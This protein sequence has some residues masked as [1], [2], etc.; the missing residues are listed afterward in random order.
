MYLKVS[1]VKVL[2]LQKNGY[3]YSVRY[4][5]PVVPNWGVEHPVK[6][7]KINLRNREMIKVAG[8]KKKKMSATQICI[9]LKRAKDY[10]IFR[11]LY[12]L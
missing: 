10:R 3:L 9:K 1:K 2:V 6:G 8:K 4:F 12:I 11:S 5:S 7:H